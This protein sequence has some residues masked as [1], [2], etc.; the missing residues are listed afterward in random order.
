MIPNFIF[1]NII[2]N[3]SSNKKTYIK[4]I[5]EGETHRKDREVFK[6]LRKKGL[7]NT[8]SATHIQHL[9]NYDNQQS[10]DYRKDKLIEE[11]KEDHMN[12]PK[13]YPNHTLSKYADGIYDI[14][15]DHY[16]RESYDNNNGI[17][18]LY[19]NFGRD[20]NNAFFS[21][22]ELV[23][24]EG[25]GVYFKTF[26][27]PDIIGHEY[28]HWFQAYETDFIYFDQAGALNEHISDV[29][30]M[31]FDQI[32]KNQNVETSKWLIGEGIWTD[33]V[34]GIAL[35]SMKNP[36]TAYNDPIV[37]SDPQPGHMDN[38]VVTTD[39]DNGVHINSGILNKAFY[40]ANIA[41]GGKIH[42]NGIGQ[43]WYNTILKQ[44][45]LASNTNF[46]TFAQATVNNANDSD[47]KIIANAWRDVGIFVDT[48][49][50]P[51]PPVDPVDPVPPPTDP[52]EPEEPCPVIN[53]IK[54]ISSI[55]NR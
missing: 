14:L 36:G 25:D 54:Q 3:D 20:Y 30:G 38:Y 48:P 39:D 41:K 19:H 42:E 49:V 50:D 28:A 24:G 2:K 31:T 22:S 15:H 4:N 27:L 23:F 47:K 46:Q 35:R 10:W 37:G 21:G 34:N 33:R 12:E 17:V 11:F 1:E 8:I 55:F 9:F 5:L 51:I 52:V 18:T 16:H 43:V 32:Y 53:A 7:V 26:I 6:V 40:L 44:N 45:G 13:K 29:F